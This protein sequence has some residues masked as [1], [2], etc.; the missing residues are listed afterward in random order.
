MVTA[1]RDGSVY[2]RDLEDLEQVSTE[3]ISHS[4]ISSG[5]TSVSLS[6]SKPFIYTAGG[7]GSIFIYSLEAEQYPNL[8]QSAPLEGTSE[9]ARV[10]AVES[11]S[12]ENIMLFTEILSLQFEKANQERKEQFRKDVMIELNVIRS[13]LHEL[14]QENE[15]VS[16]IEKLDRDEFVID[17]LKADQFYQEGEKTCDAIRNEAEKTV[18][19]LELLKERVIDST[20]NKMQVQSRAIQSI[21]QDGAK[22]LL[23][24]FGIRKRTPAEEKALQAIKC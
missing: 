14:L 3:F 5:V 10:P 19:K 18:L 6:R 1:S 11:T 17:V 8:P 22:M 16:E 9:I 15:Q 23:Y 4:I 20:W 12:V 2:I 24:N 7:D 13:K 21:Q